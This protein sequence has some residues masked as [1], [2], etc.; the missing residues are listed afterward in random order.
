MIAEP[1]SLSSGSSVC[2]D[3]CHIKWSASELAV[4]SVFSI[5]GSSLI[6]CGARGR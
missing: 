4:E 2:I 5:G 1:I 3:N 6:S